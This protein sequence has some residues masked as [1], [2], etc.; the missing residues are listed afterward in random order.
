MNDEELIPVGD[1]CYHK[2]EPGVR[3]RG[4]PCPFWSLAPNREEQDNGCCSYLKIGPEDTENDK[5]EVGLERIF[6]WDQLKICGIN[7]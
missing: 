7:D 2:P 1:Y 4:V 3:G 6:L 5:N